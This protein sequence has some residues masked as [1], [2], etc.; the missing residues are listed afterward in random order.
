MRITDVEIYVLV[1]PA[2]EKTFFTS[3]NV[4]S[5]VSELVVKVHTDEGIVGLGE[6]HGGTLLGV[7]G[8]ARVVGAAAVVKEGLKGLLIGEDPLN[9]ERLW[10]KMFSTTFRQGWAV[11]GWSRP[12]I[13]TAIG[14]LDSALWDIKGKAAGMPIW[15]L[16]GGAR[17]SALCYVTGGYYQEGK[18]VS[19]L[20]KECEGYLKMGYTGIKIKV[21]RLAVKEDLKRVKAVRE[22]IGPDVK[23]MVDINEG[24]DVLTAIQAARALEEFNIYWLEEPVHWY[25]NV[26]GLA[27]VAASTRIPIASGEQ[28]FTRWAARDLI[29]RG[30][31]R[32]MQFDC[33]RAGG[34]TEWLKIAGMAASHHVQMAPHH[35]PQI[36]GHLCASVP[37]GLILE[38]FPDPARDPIWGEL[39]AVRPEIKNSEIVFPEDRPGWG[40]EL[41]EKVM[42]KRAVKVT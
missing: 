37:N 2:F 26:D 25:D 29:E 3:I 17:N 21:G 13:M 15:K 9:N 1:W 14:T 19:D 20:V 38:T 32:V 42:K 30:G 41:D 7:K 11:P 8:D 23:L 28:L 39:F 5:T 6:G 34:P 16:L 4:L 35:D 22:A 27:Q 36:H 31:I 18:T 40:L 12:Q 10:E 24:W 33:T